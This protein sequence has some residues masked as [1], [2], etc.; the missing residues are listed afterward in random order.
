MNVATQAM[1]DAGKAAEA[2]G[3]MPGEAAKDIKKASEHE[4]TMHNYDK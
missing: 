2:Q 3:K 1:S 4:K